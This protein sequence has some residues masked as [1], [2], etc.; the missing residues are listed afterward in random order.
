MPDPISIA[1]ATAVTAEVAGATAATAAMSA[2]ET[3]A[4]ATLAEGMSLGS[5][6]AVSELAA[7]NEALAAAELTGGITAVG[8]PP[9]ALLG[10]LEIEPGSIGANVLAHA[11][12]SGG[13][14]A[15]EL[16]AGASELSIQE[17]GTGVAEVASTPVDMAS[18]A[19]FDA[20]AW[21]EARVTEGVVK[22]D[23]VADRFRPLRDPANLENYIQHL[24]A[25]DPAFAAEMGRRVDQVRTVKGPADLDAALQQIRKSTTGQ[26]GESM[27]IDG[28]RPYFKGVE[29]QSRVELPTGTTII[30]GRLLEARQPVVLGR[31]LGVPEGGNLALEVKTGQPRYLAREI[32]HI[33]NKQVQGHLQVGD[34]SLVVMSRDVHS[35]T[36]ERSARDAVGAAGSRIMAL[37][38]KKETMDQALMRV[39]GERAG[40]MA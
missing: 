37:L 30:D 2:T 29:V 7:A 33:A 21:T 19:P 8:G 27:A 14:L 22:P 1:A 40:R 39:I 9:E 3:A 31:G 32:P 28:F 13:V 18:G 24:D 35:L 20:A 6:A 17:V 15:Q 5:A 11:E 4:A 34:Q 16:S 36:T 12:T 38:P 26:L 10:A 25:R 23:V